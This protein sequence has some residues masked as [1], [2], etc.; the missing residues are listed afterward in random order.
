M[1]NLAGVNGCDDTVTQELEEAGIEIHSYDFLR[2]RGEVPTS[3]IGTLGGWGFERAWYYW[4]AKGPGIPPEIA[5]KL[6]KTHGTDVRVD[7]H[8]GSI[9]PR[10]AFKGF[11]VGH[12]HIDTQDGLNAIAETIREII[13]ENGGHDE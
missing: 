10:K 3:I 9:S 8:C 7:G 13:S 12:Y 5:D 2:D 11:A 6:H 4:I 1:E